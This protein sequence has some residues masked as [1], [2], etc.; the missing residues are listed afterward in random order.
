VIPCSL[1]TQGLRHQEYGRKSGIASWKVAES[2]GAS[3]IVHELFAVSHQ[4]LAMTS[5]K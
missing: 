5:D 4:P 2:T 1:L 3:S